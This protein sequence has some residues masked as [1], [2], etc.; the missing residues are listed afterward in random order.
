MRLFAIS[1][2]LRAHSTN[3]ALLKRIAALAPEEMKITV[4]DYLGEIP[5]FSPDLEGELTPEPVLKFA[6]DIAASDGLI[7]ASPEYAH[8]IPGA[9][10]NCLD[11]LVSRYEV[12]DKP[13]MI[14]NASERGAH[15]KAALAE[16]LTTMSLIII[17][18]TTV[19]VHLI[20][21]SSKD[22]E[23]IVSQ[24]D[25]SDQIQAYLQRF[26]TALHE[27]QVE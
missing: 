25:I 14:V 18:D 20:G 22:V 10:K 6:A 23:T 11:W 3:T 21:K 1:G 4:C 19:T 9:L 17:P 8:G 7:F 12:I 16:V 15:A 2:S 27:S 13:V 5:V 24:S 26:R